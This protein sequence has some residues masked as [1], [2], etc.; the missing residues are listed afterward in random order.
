VEE[1]R[2]PAPLVLL[3]REDLFRK[4]TVGVGGHSRLSR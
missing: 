1:E 3:G 2:D 4:L